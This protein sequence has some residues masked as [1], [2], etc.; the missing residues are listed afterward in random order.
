MVRTSTTLGRPVGATGEETRR[1]I[2]E[3]AVKCVADVGYA[4]ATI[5][6]IARAADL[7]SG[8]L[9]HYFPNKAELITATV[10]DMSAIVLPR[11][12]EA[13]ERGGALADQ[14]VAILDECE[15][16]H[17]DYP[18]L[19]AFDRAIR[20]ENAQQLNLGDTRAALHTTIVG[21]VEEGR[22]NGA[23]ADGID[24][25]S[26][27]NAIFTLIRGLNEYTPASPPDEYH[28]TVQALKALV[29]GLLFRSGTE[30]AVP[31]RRARA[32]ARRRTH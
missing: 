18:H 10:A 14:V 23:L 11:L 13:A 27:A 29:S 7:T 9:Y 32:A 3:A 25:H 21:L 17:R 26:A 30:R 22:R 12:T 24:V 5:R 1:R 2:V 4:R 31:A 6:E 19:A 8:S 15:A 28:R 16:I 20:A